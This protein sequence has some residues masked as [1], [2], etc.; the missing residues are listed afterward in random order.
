MTSKMISKEVP[1][2]TF[3]LD[4]ASIIGCL[5]ITPTLPGIHLGKDNVS[6]IGCHFT[7]YD[8]LSW[9]HRFILRRFFGYNGGL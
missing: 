2:I 4:K 6:I 7:S 5:I 9:L 8:S 1:G 3:S